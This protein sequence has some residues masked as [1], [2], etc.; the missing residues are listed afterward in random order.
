[1]KFK[2]R[3][4]ALALLG[5]AAIVAFA[6]AATQPGS[7]TDTDLKPKDEVYFLPGEHVELP[8]ES[9]PS[10]EEMKRFNEEA[11]KSFERLQKENPD[12]DLQN[13]NH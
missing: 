8:I 9:G 3:T 1:M 12:L 2:K 10:L 13:L 7:T 4:F 6:A 11:D 5:I